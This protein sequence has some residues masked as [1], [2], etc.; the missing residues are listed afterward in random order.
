MNTVMSDLAEKVADGG[1]KDK[2]VPLPSPDLINDREA[3]PQVTADLDEGPQDSSITLAK[4]DF[5][6]KAPQIAQGLD[7]TIDQGLG[8]GA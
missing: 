4:P 7:Q 8:M 2:E 5:G 3:E 1:G 6:A